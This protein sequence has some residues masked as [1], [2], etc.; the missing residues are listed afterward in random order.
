MIPFRDETFVHLASLKQKNAEMLER[1]SDV[2]LV[3]SRAKQK[4]SGL[5]EQLRK[6]EDK[7]SGN[8]VLMANQVGCSRT[9]SLAMLI[10]LV[11]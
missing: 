11:Y 6:L 2:D 5:E 1:S 3:L 9:T 4:V 7:I 8:D 10:R